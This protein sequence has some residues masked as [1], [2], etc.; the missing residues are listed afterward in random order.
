MFKLEEVKSRLQSQFGRG[1]TSVEWAEAIG[2]SCQMLKSQL[3]SGTSSRE[4]LIYANLRMVVHI[5]KQ[6]QGRGL[7]LQDLMRV[8]SL[9]H[10]L[11]HLYSVQIDYFTSWYRL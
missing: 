6:Y 5:A 9:E 8:T 7:G 1:P 2:I 3:R 10:V 4:K 11:V